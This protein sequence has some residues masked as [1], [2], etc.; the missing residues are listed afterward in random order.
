VPGSPD[1]VDLTFTVTEKGPP[2]QPDAGSQ[3]LQRRPAVAPDRSSRTT[4]SA[5]GNYLGLELNTSK[6]LR[7]IVLSTVD[8]YF[9]ADGISRAFD[10]Y[11]RTVKPLNSQGESYQLITPGAAVRFGVPYS[12]FDTVF[13]GIGVESTRIGTSDTALPEHYFR[14]PPSTAPTASRRYR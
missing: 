10:L 9:T 5:A 14:L 3:L 12:E 11:Y 7:T 6:S 4:S 8:P 1:Q 13:V 2:V